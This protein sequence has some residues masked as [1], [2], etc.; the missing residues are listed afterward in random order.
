MKWGGGEDAKKQS[1]PSSP[2]CTSLSFA[3]LSLVGLRINKTFL[4]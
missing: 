3:V 2:F 1:S 4:N